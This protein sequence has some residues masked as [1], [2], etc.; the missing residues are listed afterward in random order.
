MPGAWWYRFSIVVASVFFA[1]MALIATFAF[2]D[3]SAEEMPGW[4]PEVFHRKISLGLDLQGG[5]HLI[6][7][8]KIDKAINDKLDAIADTIVEDLKA[9][10]KGEGVKWSAVDNFRRI[11]FPTAEAKDYAIKELM[12]RYGRVNKYE[13][14]A[15]SFKIGFTDDERN[16]Y[17]E[18]VMKKI[19]ETLNNR[20]DEFNVKESKVGR[21]GRDQ[22]I[23]ELP[24]ISETKDLLQ[25]EEEMKKTF[26]P[27]LTRYGLLG[28][29]GD[30]AMGYFTRKVTRAEIQAV[31]NRTRIGLSD[32]TCTGPDDN[33]ACTLMLQSLAKK[34]FGTT[35]RL[36]FRMVNDEATPLKDLEGK[37]PAGVEYAMGRYQKPDG[38]STSYEYVTAKNRDVLES[39]LR[40]SA[41]VKPPD[42]YEYLVET[43]KDNIGETVY[44]SVLVTKTVALTGDTIN[45]ARV[46]QDTD[47]MGGY[48]VS[49]SFDA[50]GAR[51]FEE[52]SGRNIGK[53]M[54]II[55]DNTVQSAPVFQA[56]IG[57]GQARITL[58]S[59]I[60]L[61]RS[62]QDA[63]D[64]AAVLRAGSL[65]ADVEVIFKREV[66][67]SLGDDSIKAGIQSI[68]V[69]A[70]LVFIFTVIYYKLSGMV[71][72]LMLILNIGLILACMALFEAT[73]TLPGMAG[74]LLTL[75]MAVDA[76]IIINERIREE[77]A[78]G[79][80]PRQAVT[81]GYEKA[82]SAI[83]D[84]NITTLLAA[85]ILYQYGTGPIRGFAVTL[86]IGI[87]T[88]MF[89]GVSASRLFMDYM[90][91]N[92]GDKPLSI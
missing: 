42:G 44:R 38:G 5:M 20:I 46:A 23:V 7:Q 79:R 57:G 83:F 66:G 77:I 51:V 61:E 14:T 4:L 55:L 50:T 26:G 90:A 91:N 1:V 12:P 86:S 39:F 17:G 59:D 67:P 24:G 75:G 29:G 15:T 28:E 72:V 25:V 82:F 63:Q 22:I 70:A 53:R 58:N 9:A 56:R 78:A 30:K 52:L 21:R 84:A 34:R 54:A 8:A 60:S 73:L 36:E 87:F 74:L 13:E 10:K 62:L 31:F 88:T 41:L 49:L 3:K 45:D 33:Y 40:D 43:D 68:V 27:A 16:A 18:D 85:I 2:G 47:N 92:R 65:P 6:L 76:S 11:D 35:A 19:V 80:G 81:L 71:A 32:V 89:T 64:L 69:G 48:F 37:L